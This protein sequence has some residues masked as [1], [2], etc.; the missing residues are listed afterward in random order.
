MLVNPS[1]A[2]L[3]ALAGNPGMTPP[4]GSGEAFRMLA[5]ET[6]NLL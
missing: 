3:A 4:S 2:L 5:V 6:L 1:L